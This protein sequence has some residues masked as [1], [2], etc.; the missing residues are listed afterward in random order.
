V[1]RAVTNNIALKIAA[2]I[3]ALVLWAFAKGEQRGD[4]LMSVPLI[5]RNLPEGV[6]TVEK[7]PETIDVVLAGANKELVSLTLW[8]NVYAFVD[9]T[10]A[11]PGRSLRVSLS[12]ANVVV[13]RN[14]DVLALEVRN[15]KSLDLDIDR[16][17][18]KRTKI[19]PRMEGELAEGYFI[20]GWA[21]SIPDSVTTYGPASVVDFLHSV[22]TESLNVSGRRDRVEASRSIVFDEPWNLHSVPRD[23]RVVVEVEGTRT[24]T[25]AN[26]PVVFEHESGFG[27]ATISPLAAEIVLSGAEHR[28]RNLGSGDITVVVDARG[29]P[30]GTH[31]LIPVVETPEGVDLEQ[32]M[33]VRFTVT[34][35]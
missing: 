14:V 3:L 8:G 34:L 10:D 32:V 26:A 16:L 1:S 17:I 5:V 24:V 18:S 28:V 33:P 7:V 30:K 11:Q 12:P 22:R 21:T 13:P 19:D 25:L 4:R 35:E 29:L 6:T 23:V 31:E 9:M 20:L 27:S 15:P 2:V